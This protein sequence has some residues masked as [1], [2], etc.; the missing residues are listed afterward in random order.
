MNRRT[1]ANVATTSLLLGAGVALGVVTA[2]ANQPAPGVANISPP[3]STSPSPAHDPKVDRLIATHRCWTS[4]DAAPAGVI[5]GHAVVTVANVVRYVGPALTGD[6]LNK[7]FK[8]TP[9]E[10]EVVHA[11]CR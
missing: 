8:H 5:P 3:S 9:S 10:I 7:I 4:N 1:V 6:A 11:F 2:T